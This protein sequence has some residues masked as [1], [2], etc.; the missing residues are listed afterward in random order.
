MK[1][2]AWHYVLILAAASMM[3]PPTLSAQAVP[4]ITAPVNDYADIITPDQEKKLSGM[5]AAHREKTGVQIAVLTVRTTGGIPI[6]E[7]SLTTAEKWGGGTRER[8]DGL[9]FTVAVEDRR[10]RIE[11]GYGLEGY[12]TDVRAG[13]MLD[14]IR[15]DFRN[16]NYDKGIE[17]VVSQI[18]AA[19]GELR[20]G[21]KPAAPARVRG[22]FLNFLS[23]FHIIYALMGAL[24]GSLFIYRKSLGDRTITIGGKPSSGRRGRS[25][26]KKLREK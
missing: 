14:G 25:S 6:E 5:I 7:F 1:R 19:T 15:D 24:V 21:V 18:M 26:R 11:V 2:T 3:A 4:E 13:R 22:A 17:K 10:M 12:L 16:N 8:D 23:R 9:L 20:P